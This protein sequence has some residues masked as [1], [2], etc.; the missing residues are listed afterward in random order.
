MQDKVDRI[1]PS[2]SVSN[3]R[4]NAQVK[5]LGIFGEG[6][7]ASIVYERRLYAEIVA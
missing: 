3:I 1:S 7:S 2:I 6:D 4:S 5:G